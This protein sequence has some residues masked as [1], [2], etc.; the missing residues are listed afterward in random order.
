MNAVFFTKTSLRSFVWKCL[1]IG[2]LGVMLASL[3]SLCRSQQLSNTH[4][5]VVATV[6]FSLDFP[7]SDPEHYSISVDFNGHGRYESGAGND[8][9]SSEF[10]VSPASREKL[11][12]LTEQAQFFSGN[13]D[14]GNRKLAFSGTKTLTYH[15]GQHD[16][17]A[18]YDYSN[19]PAV[20]ELTVLFQSMAGTLE[21]GRRLVY[22]HRYQKLALD[23]ELKRMEAQV[24]N[25]ELSELQ[26]VA[27][28]LQQIADDTSVMNV[29]R[30][31]ARELIQIGTAASPGRDHNMR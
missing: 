9:Y 29:V 21:Y 28:L 16:Q 31:R 24:R 3:S 19:L 5:P 18:R 25:N 26:T 12:A 14:S 27:P 7:H 8:S 11:F 17:T 1:M 10:E 22:D 13:V 2:M 6:T 4:P 20:R 15:D 23:D 30:A